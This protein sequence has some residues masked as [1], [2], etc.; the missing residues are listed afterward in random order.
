MEEEC[1]EDESEE[2]LDGEIAE[3]EEN[4]DQEWPVPEIAEGR[5]NRERIIDEIRVDETLKE[6]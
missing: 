1:D 6:V 3:T 4:K 2:K 5:S